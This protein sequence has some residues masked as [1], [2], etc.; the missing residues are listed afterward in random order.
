MRGHVDDAVLVDAAFDDHVD[1]D[2]PQLCF[3]RG[4]DSIEDLADWKVDVV[5]RAEDVVVE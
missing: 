1:L 2:R 5:H 3:V 4:V